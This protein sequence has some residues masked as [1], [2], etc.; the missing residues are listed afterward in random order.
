VAIALMWSSLEKF[1]YPDWFHPLVEERPFLTFGLPRDM[2]IPMAGVAEFTL[3]FGLLATPLMRRLSAIALLLIFTLAVFPFGRVDL[4]GHALIMMTIVA[5]AVDH[6][7]D[8]NFMQ[9]IRRNTKLLPASLA[10]FLA[11]FVVSYWGLHAVFFGLDGGT[12]P[13]SGQT[14][15]TPDPERPHN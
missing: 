7:R 10:G 11:I 9:S 15:H 8:L 12:P 1:A 3:G 14:T 4:I 6:T 13:T 5:I 2:F